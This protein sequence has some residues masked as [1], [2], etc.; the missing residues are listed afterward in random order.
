[1]ELGFF[2]LVCVA[3]LSAL[4]VVPGQATA[5]LMSPGGDDVKER[6]GGRETVAEIW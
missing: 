5:Q 3:H 1:M 6:D 4:A 2:G